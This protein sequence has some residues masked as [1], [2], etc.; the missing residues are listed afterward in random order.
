M[1]TLTSLRAPTK[2]SLLVREKIGCAHNAFFEVPA[3]RKSQKPILFGQIEI[4]PVV[5]E[6]SGGNS[7]SP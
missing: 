3:R 6:S 4:K 5:C 1:K 7:K 2:L